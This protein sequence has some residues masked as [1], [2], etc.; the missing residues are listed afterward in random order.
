MTSL[1]WRWRG[2]EQEWFLLREHVQG[3]RK[4]GASLY[5]KTTEDNQHCCVLVTDKLTLHL[6]IIAAKAFI[7]IL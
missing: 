1:G 2:W 5:L 7:K 4:E 6:A 3:L